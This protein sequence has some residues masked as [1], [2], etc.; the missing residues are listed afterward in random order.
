MNVSLYQAAA[1]MNAHSRWQE[2]IAENLSSASVPGFRK[3]QISFSAVEAG[4]DSNATGLN[5]PRYV[6]PSANI[7]TNF[8]EGEVRSSGAPLDFAIDGP[9]MF[10]VKLLNGTKAYTRDGQFNINAQ[11][12]L[13]TKQGYPVLGD[14]GPLQLDTKNPAPVSVSP[15]GEVSQGGDVVGR[16]RMVEFTEPQFLSPIGQGFF[17]WNQ[18]TPPPA[19]VVASSIRQ[20]FLEASNASATLEMSNLVLAMRMFESNQK[21]L[22]MQDE[23]M[24]KVI[25][26]LG[27][28]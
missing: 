13:V 10:E 24:G 8:L 6:I 9:A 26:E 20:G 27:R 1:A 2:M 25:T 15:S 4:L 12:Q 3:Q 28:P 19:N 14:N 22:Q 17:V 18:D 11:G 5:A 7:S 16:M 23:R 21:V